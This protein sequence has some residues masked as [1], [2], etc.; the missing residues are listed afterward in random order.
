MR[1]DMAGWQSPGGDAA[2]I[3]ASVRFPLPAGTTAEDAR[4]LY[5]KNIALYEQAPG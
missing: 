3:I 5:E 4:T 2:M 1:T